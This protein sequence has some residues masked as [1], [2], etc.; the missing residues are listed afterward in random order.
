[1][2]WD[3]VEE[4]KRE[5]TAVLGRD[6][7]NRSHVTGYKIHS[8][9][10][11]SIFVTPG[12]QNAGEL[13][14]RLEQAVTRHLLSRAL[15]LYHAGHEI[16]FGDLGISQHGIH[17]YFRHRTL[18]WDD[19]SSITFPSAD[20]FTLTIWKREKLLPWAALAKSKVPNLPTLRALVRAIQ[21]RTSE[22]D[23]CS[24]QDKNWFV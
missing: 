24:F 22:E 16:T 19:L 15:L 21:N 7:V 12:F 8:R 10:G 2:R 13:Y 18:S 4:L 5:E 9:Y 23:A 17:D 1:M 11:H 14:Y 20:G 6:G 3:E